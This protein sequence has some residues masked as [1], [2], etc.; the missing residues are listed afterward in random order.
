MIKTVTKNWGGLQNDYNF[1]LTTSNVTQHLQ[2]CTCV[3][4]KT[5]NFTEDDIGSP[6]L[7]V[8]LEAGDLLYFPRGTIHQVRTLL[9]FVSY[10]SNVSLL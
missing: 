7:D 4:H 8:T 1:K 9:L 10:N 3:L 5:D 6:L 2:C